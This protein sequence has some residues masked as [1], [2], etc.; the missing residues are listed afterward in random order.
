MPKRVFISGPIQGI[1]TNQSYRDRLSELL[2]KYGYVPVDPWLREKV[3]YRGPLEQWWNKIPPIEFIRR[4]L[5]DIRNCDVLV[6]YL[7]NLSAG[8][9]MEMFY[10]YMME[11]TVIT[12]CKIENP[13]PWI[14]NHTKILL[15]T[16]HE[17]EQLLKE[18]L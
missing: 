3:L 5:E 8:T 11:K 7:P 18:G 1:E 15:G 17:F 13:S 16:M 9:C 6:A 14:T 4:D 12:I 10:A 2:S